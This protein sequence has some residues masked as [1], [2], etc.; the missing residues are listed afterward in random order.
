MTTMILNKTDSKLR[1]RAF[2]KSLWDQLSISVRTQHHCQS[3]HMTNQVNDYHGTHSRLSRLVDT[4]YFIQF[5]LVMVSW[6]KRGKA[7]N[8]TYIS[9][10]SFQLPDPSIYNDELRRKSPNLTLSLRLNFIH[11]FFSL[12][13]GL[14]LVSV[15]YQ[16][17]WLSEATPLGYG[18]ACSP[19]PLSHPHFFFF[20]WPQCT[21]VD[22]PPLCDVEGRGDCA[23]RTVAACDWQ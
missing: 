11:P 5:G 7:R 9:L 20:F 16:N 13:F 8:Y 3:S 6:S 19:L 17:G 22:A 4:V 12:C 21:S 23:P 2:E 1:S 10:E 15:L 14:I 18:C